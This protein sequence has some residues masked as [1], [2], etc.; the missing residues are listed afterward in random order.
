M[1]SN[2]DCLIDDTNEFADSWV[3]LYNKNNYDIDLSNYQIADSSNK[4]WQLPAMLLHPKE[5]VVIFCDKQANGLH[6]D[7]RLDSGK[8]GCVYLF[9]SHQLVDKVENLK[10][11]PAPNISY[12]RESDGDGE[13]GYLLKSSP[14]KTNNGVGI[15]DRSHILGNPVFSKSGCVFTNKESVSIVLSKPSDAPHEAVIIYT[16]DGS[17][18][19]NENG[20]V[21]KSPI[22]IHNSIIIK[23]KLV[24]DGWLSQRSTVNSYIFHKRELTLPILSLSTDKRYIND[25]KL[26]IYVE[27]DYRE[28]VANYS[29]NWRRPV[30]I[31]LFEKEGTP[32][33]INQLCEF[34][35]AGA[36]TRTYPLKS[37]NIYANKRFGEKRFSYEFFPDQKPGITDFKSLVLRNAGGR[38][39]YYTYIRDALIQ[40][41]MG[42]NAD[43][44]YQAYKPVILYMNG[45]YKGIINIRERSDEDFIYSNYNGLEDIDIVENTTQKEDDKFVINTKLVEGTLDNYASFKSFYEQKGHSL[46]EYEE[47]MDWKEYI[48]LVAMNL[49]FCNRD[50][51]HLTAM[52]IA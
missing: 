29:F 18:P 3:D 1:Q 43:L 38:D 16:Q 48:N 25:S 21:Y 32:S 33:V 19:S 20:I 46:E 4:K 5:Y 50:S 14:Y 23:A 40:R 7:F 45:E 35:I 27:G 36:S 17:E 47:W 13:W 9:E 10:K 49:Y 37:I 52:A 15:V 39:F 28:G 12:G 42:Q 41:T 11:Q 8:G 31:E 2:V 22:E 44:D 24:C 34:R 51:L 6:T 30:Q 26:G